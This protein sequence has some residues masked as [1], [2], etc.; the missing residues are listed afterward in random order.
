MSKKASFST[1]QNNSMRYMLNYV[2]EYESVK[3]GTHTAMTCL[4]NVNYLTISI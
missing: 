4:Y 2:L 3:A 1:L